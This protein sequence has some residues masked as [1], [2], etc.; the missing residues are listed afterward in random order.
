MRFFTVIIIILHSLYMYG[1]NQ[2]LFKGDFC[3]ADEAPML[4]L[5]GENIV[6]LCDTAFV[7]NKYRMHLYEVSREMILKNNT[8][9]VTRLIKAYDHT[10]MIVSGSYDSL[11]LNY[12]KLEELFRTS[13]VD[14]KLTLNNT[15]NDLV[16]ATN[17]LNN[18]EKMLN[19]AVKKLGERD[20][21]AWIKKTA[22]FG[23]GLIT[24]VLIMMIVN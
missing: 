22:F 20:K 6:V 15:Q 23:V 5:S 4:V 1:Q 2:K 18:T 12:R 16:K 3:K 14:N 7:I 8:Q 9:N 21:Y 10:L 11:L 19:D 24:G 13:M 17:T